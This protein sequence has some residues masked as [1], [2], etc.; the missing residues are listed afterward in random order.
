[1][2]SEKSTE[3]TSGCF[4]RQI[5]HTLYEVHYHFSENAIETVNDKIRR[6]IRHEIADNS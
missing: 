1:M 4:E 2:M 3:T 6:A 5:G